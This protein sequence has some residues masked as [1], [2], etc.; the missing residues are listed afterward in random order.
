MPI[1]RMPFGCHKDK[2]LCEVPGSYLLWLLGRK[3]SSSIRNAV[4]AELQRRG[5]KAPPPP[6]PKIPPC[7]SC[8]YRGRVNDCFACQWQEVSNGDR[9]IR[10]VCGLC[11]GFV[12]WL[13]TMEPFIQQADS[14]SSDTAILDVL[15]AIEDAGARLESDG[16]TCWIH[17]QDSPRV[18]EDLK[19]RLRECCARL[20]RMVGPTRPTGSAP[21]IAPPAPE[22]EPRRDDSRAG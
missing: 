8:L 10:A 5:L 7:R 19:A 14:W 15:L 3:V 4:S 13:P 17:W 20:A 16:R 9:R 1:D 11:R 12:A 18:S 6:L 2:K 22:R 21:P